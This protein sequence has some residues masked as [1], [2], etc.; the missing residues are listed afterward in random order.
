MQTQ[1][2]AL[3]DA[4][5]EGTPNSQ[6]A[7]PRSALGSA[8]LPRWQRWRSSAPGRSPTPAR[9][10]RKDPVTCAARMRTS[11]TMDA[12]S[13]STS[14]VADQLESR[15]RPRHLRRCVSEVARVPRGGLSRRW[16]ACRSPRSPVRIWLAPRHPVDRTVGV[17]L[18]RRSEP[19]QW[20]SG[21]G[22]RRAR[23]RRS[24]EQSLLGDRD[25]QLAR[26]VEHPAPGV[27]QPALGGR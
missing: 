19:N 10:T 5:M 2:Q 17:T 6:L 26:G 7:A 22:Q 24:A 4:S 3:V 14:R 18:T 23:R 12:L 13:R 15:S 20:S 8:H 16:S 1:R 27:P 25:H 11:M 21:S 9:S